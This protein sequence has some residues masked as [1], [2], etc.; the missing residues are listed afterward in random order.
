MLDMSSSFVRD[1]PADYILTEA[2]RASVDDNLRNN[3]HSFFA[4][5]ALFVFDNPDIDKAIVAYARDRAMAELES[6]DRELD[7]YIR[8]DELA[9]IPDLIEF[10]GWLSR[11][12]DEDTAETSD[13]E[14]SDVDSAVMDNDIL[15][16]YLENIGVEIEGD[17]FG[18]DLVKLAKGKLIYQIRRRQASLLV[19][20]DK[21]TEISKNV[22]RDFKEVIDSDKH[23][24][25]TKDD[26]FRWA[27][28]SEFETPKHYLHSMDPH[29]RDY[30]LED[31]PATLELK[32]RQAS[33][34]GK[35]IPW[36]KPHI[37]E[38][39]LWKEQFPFFEEQ[40]YDLTVGISQIRMELLM[41]A[42]AEE[43]I[44]LWRK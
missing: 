14:E 1:Y 31:D 2:E 27:D 7:E 3:F 33:F 23:R 9:S 28:Y 30:D 41:L 13:Q 18:D 36:P 37:I 39:P 35:N 4:L 24:K 8:E 38:V 11:P 6:Y 40:I 20:M 26:P 44:I 19:K 16:I 17:I 25:D 34:R 22:I 10:S 12:V 32:A 21:W 5:K 43:R 42:D 29:N 15:M